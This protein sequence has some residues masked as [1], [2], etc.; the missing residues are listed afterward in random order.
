MAADK[1]TN[2]PAEA[3]DPFE[4]ARRRGEEMRARIAKREAQEKNSSFIF[5]YIINSLFFLLKRCK[6][7]REVRRNTAEVDK[8][9]DF[10]RS[11]AKKS[12]GKMSYPDSE[13]CLC[14]SLLEFG[15][16]EMKIS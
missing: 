10:L 5:V 2:T 11:H 7:R 4:L 9:R 8:K 14:L 12:Q 3:Q 13:V 6:G 16:S 1:H 15:Q